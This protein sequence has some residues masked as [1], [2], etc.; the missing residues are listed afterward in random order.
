MEVSV[1]EQQR[2]I[3]SRRSFL[4]AAGAACI[5][6]PLY[7]SEVSRHEI[8][9]E[10]HT[11]RINRLPEPFHGLKIVQIS[12]FHYAEFTEPYFLRDMVDHVN[13]L[14]PDAVFLNGDFVTDGYVFSHARNRQ[15][16]YS[17]AEILNGIH[18]PVRYSVLGN[19]DSTFAEAAV[20]DA[21]KINGLNL[22]DN[23]YEPLERDGRRLW[24]G[25]T[26][27]AIW[28][29]MRLDDAI[30]PTSRK[31]NEPLILMVHEPDVLPLVARRKADLLLSGHTHGGQVRFPFLPAMHLPPL[32]R[33]Y[34]EGLLRLG[35]TQLYVNRGVGTVGLPFRF[36]C[37]PEIAVLTLET[38]ATE[39]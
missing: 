22:L 26:G 39:G 31:D 13:R 12:D 11:I 24:I 21:L 4:K 7:A 3:I 10:R 20:M 15:F 14:K 37:P 23:R 34:V 2:R 5:G 28:R 6:V 17:C 18:C 8:S 29:K 33:K 36:N 16:A 9:I 35:P 25:G 32:G 38:A 19:H 30:P 27:D 1:Q